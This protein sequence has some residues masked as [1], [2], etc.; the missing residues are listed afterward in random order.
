MKNITFFRISSVTLD[1][2]TDL[3]IIKVNYLLITGKIIQA[4]QAQCYFYRVLGS[5]PQA[6][7]IREYKSAHP[8]TLWRTIK[9]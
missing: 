5:D 1:I 6:D 7:H 9:V 4:K 3:I 8:L 2:L